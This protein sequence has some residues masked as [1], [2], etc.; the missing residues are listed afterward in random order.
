MFFKKIKVGHIK[1]IPI[2]IDYSWFLIFGLFIF[3]L[4]RYFAFSLKLDS[5]LFLPLI[6]G[7]IT[8]ILAFTCFLIHELSHSLVAIKNGIPIKHITLYM[9]GLG[10]F[11]GKDMERAGQEFKIAIAGPIANFIIAGLLFW[12]TLLLFQGLPAYY[13]IYLIFDYLIMINVIVGLFNLAPAFPLDGGRILRS[14]LWFL[15]KNKIKATRYAV[16]VGRFMAGLMFFIALHYGMIIMLLIS[17][18]IFFMGNAELKRLE[19]DK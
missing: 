3:T 15:F 7:I 13:P 18:Y 12:P 1:S 16:W 19:Q 11:L 6:M 8:V 9:L 2:Y 17:V 14:A 5:V 10:A 4:S